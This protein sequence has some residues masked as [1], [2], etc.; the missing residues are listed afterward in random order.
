MTDLYWQGDGEA[1]YLYAGCCDSEIARV[2]KRKKWWSAV[3]WLPDVSTDKEFDTLEKLKPAIEA[4]VRAWFD[5]AN[6][7]ASERPDHE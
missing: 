3:I 5:L 6:R 4:K 1:Q 7:P 2:R